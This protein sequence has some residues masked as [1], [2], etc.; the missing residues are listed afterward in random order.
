MPAADA[1]VSFHDQLRLAI[2]L[3]SEMAAR[4]AGKTSDP[5]ELPD[6]GVLPEVKQIDVLAQSQVAD[7]RA[8]LHHQ[9]SG[10][11]PRETDAARRVDRVA[12]LLFEQRPAKRPR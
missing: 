5:I 10:K 6:D 7:P 2:G 1:G 11:N 4:S 3:V 12:K 9:P 8:F